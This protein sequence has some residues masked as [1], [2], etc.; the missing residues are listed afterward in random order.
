MSELQLVILLSLVVCQVIKNEQKQLAIALLTFWN[1][2]QRAKSYN[3]T[4]Y[5]IN[6]TLSFSVDGL[7]HGFRIY[8]RLSFHPF[9]DLG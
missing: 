9:W 6:G 2:L 3:L 1:N 7:K 8:M 5:I 4:S